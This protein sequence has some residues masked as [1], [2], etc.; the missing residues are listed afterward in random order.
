ML[1]GPYFYVIFVLCRCISKDLKCDSIIHCIDGSDEDKETVRP[2][3]TFVGLGCFRMYNTFNIFGH[4]AT[5]K[6]GV[7][8]NLNRSG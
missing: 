6:Q 4:I 3:Y 8:N 1:C 2:F 5:W 7:K